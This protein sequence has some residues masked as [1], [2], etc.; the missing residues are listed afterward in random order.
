MITIRYP[1]SYLRRIVIQALKVHIGSTWGFFG[2]NL[3]P[4]RQCGGC[5]YAPDYNLSDQLGRFG[6]LANCTATSAAS[7]SYRVR[8]ITGLL[9]I[10]LA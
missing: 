6:L 1:V 7:T 5:A 9:A 10:S 3:A 2:I 4:V 8:G